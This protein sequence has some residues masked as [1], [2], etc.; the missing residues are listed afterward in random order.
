MLESL[1]LPDIRVLGVSRNRSQ[2]NAISA[3][4]QLPAQ[5]KALL[6]RSSHP[7]ETFVFHPL[8]IS[9]ANLVACLSLVPGITD[10]EFHG[11]ND[12][13]PELQDEDVCL[14]GAQAVLRLLTQTSENPE[15]LCPNLKR[16]AL[17]YCSGLFANEVTDLIRSR[18]QSIPPGTARLAYANVTFDQYLDPAVASQLDAFRNEGLD[19]S[20]VFP[21]PPTPMAMTPWDGLGSIENTQWSRHLGFLE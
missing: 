18:W 13:R 17:K 7:I 8:C 21:P 14:N 9:H 10:L 19:I 15:Y 3:N 1:V 12:Y 16:I 2:G 5:L 6:D 11:C 4:N 20:V